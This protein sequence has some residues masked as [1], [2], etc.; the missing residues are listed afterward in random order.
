VDERGYQT[1]NRGV[2][3]QWQDGEKVVVWPEDLATATARIPTPAWG[4]R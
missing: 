3:I 1:A 2:L 4:E